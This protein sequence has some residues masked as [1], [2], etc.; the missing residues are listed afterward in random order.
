MGNRAK[1]DRASCP[2][3]LA[4]DGWATLPWSLDD[5]PILT[6]HEVPSEQDA[7][8]SLQCWNQ[9]SSRPEVVSRLSRAVMPQAATRPRLFRFSSGT[10]PSHNSLMVGY[11]VFSPVVKFPSSMRI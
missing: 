11:G 4:A 3:S 5:G 6:V 7:G 9:R 1:V 10:S 8:D 2:R